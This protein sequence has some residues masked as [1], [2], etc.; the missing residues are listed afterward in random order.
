MAFGGAYDK[1]STC[2]YSNFSCSD[3]HMIISGS[4]KEPEHGKFKIQDLPHDPTIFIRIKA[5][6]GQQKT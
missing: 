3:V 2:R 4:E 1:G 5:K 6:Y